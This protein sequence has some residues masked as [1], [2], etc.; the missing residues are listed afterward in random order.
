MDDEMNNT[1]KRY[2]MRMQFIM[3]TV[4]LLASGMLPFGCRIL[5]EEGVANDPVTSGYFYML[6]RGTDDI[7]MLNNQLHE[8][9]RW[10][11]V[12]LIPD[13]SL[14]GITFDGQ[15]LWV[16]AA[17]AED[18]IY[19]LDASGDTL[20][21]VKAFDAPPTK[22]GTA[23]DL[24]WDGTSLWAL[25]SG[26]VS[27]SIGPALYKLNPADGSILETHYL[28]TQDPRGLT[29]APDH[30]D[31]YHRTFAG[32]LFYTD[33]EKNMVYRYTPWSGLFDTLF[34]S[35]TPPRGSYYIYPVGITSDGSNFWIL[36]SSGPADH[37]FKVSGAGV[38]QDR[39]D[40]PYGSPG[41]VVLTSVDVRVPPSP[42]ILSVTP[43]TGVLGSTL[44]V[45]I[46][47]NSF[48][49]GSGLTVSFGDGIT[50]DSVGYLSPSQLHVIITIAGDALPGKRNCTITNP[51]GNTVTADSC[52]TIT[53]VPVVAYLWLADQ[54]SS[55]MYQIRVSDTTVIRSWDTKVVSPSGSPQ[56]LASDGTNIW[57][58]ASG[59]DRHLYKLNTTGA[60]LDA[61]STIP[62]PTASGTLR[63]IVYEAGSMWVAVSALGTPGRIYQVDPST[64][65]V[66]DSIPSPGAEPR[67]IAFVNGE[68]YCNDTSLDSVFVYNSTNKTWHGVFAT[69]TPPGGTTGNR[70]A[71]GL[72]WDGTNFWIA[73]STGNF[74]HVFKVTP[75]GAVIEYFSAPQIG[76]AQLTGLVY[77][78]N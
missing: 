71:T 63:G 76:T 53:T 41:P 60:S 42:L 2:Q 21:T 13:S 6:D 5:D 28:P 29:W 35:P 40:L 49:S 78:Q 50:T 19:Q 57:L 73:N 1:L 75:A 74:D 27:S 65:A 43:N 45:E 36:N 8:L 25:N 17:G 4:M 15:F 16:S 39:F 22:K 38:V 31:E 12:S 44:A 69:P 20:V 48:K 46:Y 11:C 30:L 62:A 52:F 14:Q 68:I 33:V 54:S 9:K 64:G 61:I 24:A 37:L 3:L 56:G 23:R 32:G 34:S 77:T 51:G 72:T 55:T 67:G 47:G 18:R 59:T 58:C 70:F 10:S 26:S 7:V 66:R